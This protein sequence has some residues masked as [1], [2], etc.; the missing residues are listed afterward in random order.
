MFALMSTGNALCLADYGDIKEGAIVPPVNELW[1][2]VQEWLD[3]GNDW[4][5][6]LPADP[7]KQYA[8][9]LRELEGLRKAEEERGVTVNGIRYS[10][11]QG[12]RQ[13]LREALDAA[14]EFGLTAFD[15][16]KDSDGV[17]HA[18]HPV[19]DVHEALR[20]IG[21]RR[22]QLIAMEGQYADRIRAGET[23]DLGALE[24]TV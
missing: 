23:L 10:G 7:D 17:Y 14:A 1:V 18:D 12:N 5:P 16:W 22:M 20:Q 11:A 2:Q 24:W 3:A 6:E 15:G 21:L 13:A 9:L 8:P 4:K 19:A